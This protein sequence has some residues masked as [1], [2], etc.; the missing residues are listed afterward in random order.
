MAISGFLG[1]RT[2]SFDGRLGLVIRE[3]PLLASKSMLAFLF[4]RPEE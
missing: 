1:S 2:C 4:A 3:R